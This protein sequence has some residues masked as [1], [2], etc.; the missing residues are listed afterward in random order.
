MSWESIPF[1]PKLEIS[2]TTGQVT[3]RQLSNSSTYTA[4][5]TY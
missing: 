4:K 1:W 5:Y 2:A 3:G